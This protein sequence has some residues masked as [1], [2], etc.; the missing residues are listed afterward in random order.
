MKSSI[1][2]TVA[3]VFLATSIFSQD[4]PKPSPHA[5]VE[6]R[7]GLTDISVEYSRPSVKGRQIWG[8][9]VPFDQLWRAGANKAT[10][11]TTSTEIKINGEILPAGTYSF[12]ILPS[13]HL[14]WE[15]IFNT[16]TELWGTG[17]Y[18]QEKDQLRIMAETVPAMEFK[19]GLEYSFD[20]IN[21]D[22]AELIMEWEMMKAMVRIEVDAHQQAL[23]NIK[24]A[25]DESDKE[26]L[27]K[28]YRNAAAYARDKGNMTTDGLTWIQESV[29]LKD[30][31]YSYWV[32]ADLLAQNKDYSGAIEKA[33][34]AISFGKA[35]DPKFSYEE[36]I[37]TDINKWK[38]S[39]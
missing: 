38:A 34:K 36:R 32:Y 27:W 10:L 18:N 29:K 7:V 25:I 19:E 17:E 35:D 2:L 24:A 13:D 8:D 37:N 5:K 3:G 33:K 31:W 12:F 39:K 23:T 1:L 30:N 15:F 20:H 6:Q 9:L 4:L 28:V 16:E 11:F 14:G 21:D 26:N 22:G